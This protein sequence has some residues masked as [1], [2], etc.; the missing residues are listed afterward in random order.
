[1]A[2][3]VKRLLLFLALPVLIGAGP[4]HVIDG[5]T[6]AIDTTIFRLADVDAPELA[7]TCDG[8]SAQLQQC[9]AYVADALAEQIA[10]HEVDCSVVGVDDYDRQ[11][12]RCEVAGEDLSRWLVTNGLAMAFRQYSELLA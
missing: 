5:D 2:G 9:G 1:M 4:G 11:I 10:G 12:A 8:G 7:Q 3:G 6:F